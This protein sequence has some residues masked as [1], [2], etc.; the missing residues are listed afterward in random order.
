MHGSS[1]FNFVITSF[2][3]LNPI[4]VLPIF[5]GLTAR[6]SRAVQR[7]VALFVALTVLAL[8]LIFLFLGD[9][10]LR[11]LGVSIDAFSIAGGILLLLMG[12]KIVAG[13]EGDS[14]AQLTDAAAA[15]S[16]LKEA[17][18]VYQKIVIPLAL[19]LLVDPG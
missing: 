12:L 4:G 16:E 2:A 7:L 9:D 14:T 19:P 8:L 18:T 11:F 10:L 1:F 15:G 6:E 5:I 3:L 13:E 17:E